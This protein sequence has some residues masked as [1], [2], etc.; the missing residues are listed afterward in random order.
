MGGWGEGRE[1]TGRGGGFFFGKILLSDE[2]MCIWDYGY[3]LGLGL[4]AIGY[5]WVSAWVR[6]RAREGVWD[7][8]DDTPW[9]ADHASVFAFY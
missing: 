1:R 2:D 4:G 7:S 5:T 3:T 9:V 8:T 6:A